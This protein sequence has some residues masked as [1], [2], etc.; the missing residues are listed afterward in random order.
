MP[1]YIEVLAYLRPNGGYIVNGEKYENIV[2][3]K[4]CVPF[5]ED[6]FEAAFI[7]LKNK[8]LK[9]KNDK[10][11]AKKALLERLGITAEEAALLLG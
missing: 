10:D 2:F 4:D 5:T 8:R 9:D 1:N 3:E 6:E 7:D 11:V